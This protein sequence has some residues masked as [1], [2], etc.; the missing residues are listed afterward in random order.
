MIEIGMIKSRDESLFTKMSSTKYLTRGIGPA[1]SSDNGIA[2]SKLKISHFLNGARNGLRLLSDPRE[3]IPVFAVYAKLRR[4]AKAVFLDRD[5]TLN[6]DSGYINHPDL[7][8]LFPWVAAEL[9]LLKQS[10]FS[11]VVV[12]NQSGI[13]RGLITWDQLSE[14]HAKLDRLLFEAVGIHIDH[15]EICPHHPDVNCTCRKPK[16]KLILDAASFLKVD[17]ERSFMIGDRKSDYE[18]GVAAGLKKS[19][20]IH[21]GDERSFKMAIAEILKSEPK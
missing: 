1:L 19:F 16:P 9:A 11:L 18:A 14:V 2:I 17:L 5:E 15:F 8:T 12:S 4:M 21:P 13:G 10:G 3:N 7:L 6:P 20:L